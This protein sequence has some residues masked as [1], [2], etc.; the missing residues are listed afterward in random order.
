MSEKTLCHVMSGS[1]IDGLYANIKLVS[2]VLVSYQLNPS[3]WN[4]AGKTGFF[5]VRVPN[6]IPA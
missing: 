6:I 5:W 2:G 4:W 3:A 1:D